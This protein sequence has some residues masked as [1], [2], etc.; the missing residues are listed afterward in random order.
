MAK[1][2]D[3]S[4]GDSVILMGQSYFGR[5]SA[6]VY[7]VLGVNHHSIPEIDRRLILAPIELVRDFGD[8]ANGATTVLVTLK[9]R[10]NVDAISDVIRLSL[11]AGNYEVMSWQEILTGRMGLYRMRHAGVTIL[12]IILYLIVGFGILGTVLMT[13]SER[14]REYGILM[15][16]GMKKQK[17]IVTLMYEMLYIS[18][19]GVA[20]GALLVAPIMV[21]LHHFPIHIT[22][23]LAEVMWRYNI[24]PII[25]FSQEPLII[26]KNASV[27]FLIT[28]L[29]TFVP[30]NILARLN[31]MKAIRN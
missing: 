10:E 6:E 1:F 16:I 19:I 7:P 29:V 2:L 15:A 24:E 5:K 22:G 9:N 14:K 21:L 4:A 17:L 8:L 3:I 30:I 18:F 13:N 27:V 23:N 11:N 26:I 20:A 28:V 25:I 31:L 12:K